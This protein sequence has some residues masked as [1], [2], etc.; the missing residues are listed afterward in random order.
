MLFR[1]THFL[2]L[3]GIANGD[4]VAI[5][6][7][8][9]I[10]NNMVFLLNCQNDTLAIIYNDGLNNDVLINSGVEQVRKLLKA[11]KGWL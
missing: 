4:A 7:K 9:D 2:S 5:P 11:N 8:G 6:R 10:F 3:R 1:A